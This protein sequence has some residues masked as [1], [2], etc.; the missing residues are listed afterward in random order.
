MFNI[1]SSNQH[2][3]H[4]PPSSNSPRIQEIVINADQIPMKVSRKGLKG[5]VSP[6]SSQGNTSVERAMTAD[7]NT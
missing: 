1:K 4:E 3:K 6:R 2:P 5:F 7:R